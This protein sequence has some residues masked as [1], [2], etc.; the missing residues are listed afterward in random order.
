VLLLLERYGGTVLRKFK[1]DFNGDQGIFFVP[2]LINIA[3]A[4]GV[5]AYPGDG[6]S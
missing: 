3:R 4:K 5:S 6:L 1:A 2:A